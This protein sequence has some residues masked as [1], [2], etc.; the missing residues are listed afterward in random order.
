MAE[1][2]SLDLKSP[3]ALIRLFARYRDEWMAIA[4]NG[5]RE[6]YRWARLLARAGTLVGQGAGHAPA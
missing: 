1:N 2:K 3:E 6:G 4:E 5:R